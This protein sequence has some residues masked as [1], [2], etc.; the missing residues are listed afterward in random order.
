MITINELECAFNN[1]LFYKSAMIKNSLDKTFGL[2]HNKVIKETDSYFIVEMMPK[3]FTK[4]LNSL[5]VKFNY[6]LSYNGDLKRVESIKI[7]K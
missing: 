4:G 3:S 5:K 1:T 2:F 6:T 7:E